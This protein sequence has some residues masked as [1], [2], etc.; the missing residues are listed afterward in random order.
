[1][2]VEHLRPSAAADAIALLGDA[3]GN[4]NHGSR[5]TR[6][7]SLGAALVAGRPRL[8][9]VAAGQPVGAPLLDDL[10]EIADQVPKIQ[11][12]ATVTVLVLESGKS[13]PVG[14]AFD[15][16]AGEPQDLVLPLVSLSPELGWKAYL[17]VRAAWEAGGVP[18]IAR[19]FE[20]SLTG[21]ATGDDDSVELAL[22]V[23]ATRQWQGVDAPLRAALATWLGGL[24]SNRSSK[25]DYGAELFASGLLWNRL[26]GN[27]GTATPWASRALMQ[28]TKSPPAELLLRSSM[29]CSPLAREI[30]ARCFE[31][32]V[33][34]RIR[35]SPALSALAAPPECEQRYTDFKSGRASFDSAL[36]PA[37][38]P[39]LPRDAWAFASF[40]EYLHG[41]GVSSD[42]RDPHTRLR[43]LRN[44]IAHGHYVGWKAASEA[45]Q[46]GRA[47]IPSG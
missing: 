2:L 38:C 24:T 5:R 17:H 45:V 19:Q 1:V 23:V 8:F 27:D 42:K 41:A 22:N 39:A 30:L 6:L 10:A 33:H 47:L 15:Y 7:E 43:L 3:I 29:I 28:I 20:D 11:P 18:G 40:G 9:T 46:L 4:Q 37:A 12:G 32:E 44:A 16:G 31:L 34:A 25:H 36:Y 13:R 26:A 21:A 35:L 14:E